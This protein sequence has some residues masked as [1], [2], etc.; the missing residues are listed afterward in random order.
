MNYLRQLISILMLTAAPWAAAQAPAFPSGPVRIVIP[1]AAG[2]S[3]DI[4]ARM[5]VDKL[6]R[7]LGQPVIVDNRVGADGI[8]GAQAAAQAAADGHTLFYGGTTTIVANAV[9][10]RKLP[11]DPLR[12]FA[13]VTLV[14]VSA[15][16]LLV[17]PDLPVQ[18]VAELVSYAKANP[19]KLAFGSAFVSA[20][21]AGELFNIMT[22][23]TLLSVPY[24][25]G[26]TA[27]TD[28][29]G[30]QV[31]VMFGDLFSALPFIKS[32]KVRALAVTTAR[33]T[34]AAPE[35]PTIAETLPGY[36][37]TAWGAF[38]VPA[39]TP[40][41]VVARLNSE[42]VGIIGAPEF[43]QRLLASGS[44]ANPG[45]PQALKSMVDA[46][47]ATWRRLVVDAHMEMTD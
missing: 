1:S 13:P 18:N 14:G 42:L 21:M 6:Q 36:E 31:Q 20:R 38:F 32:G 16:V 24:K 19:G 11:Y 3:L 8:I 41:P 7:A 43:R 22:G 39:K 28:L 47:V 15:L 27:H 25:S 26:V 34:A 4:S 23:A 45:T 5:M 17:N 35:L 40:A 9:L 29:V 44:D 2:G 30:G 46:D 37:L 33:R 10:R 12:D